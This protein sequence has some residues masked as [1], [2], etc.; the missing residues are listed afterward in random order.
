MIFSKEDKKRIGRNISA[1]REAYG[2]TS[3]IDFAIALNPKGEWPISDS[4][5]QK[6]EAG[7]YALREGNIRTIGALTGFSYSEIVFE[8]LTDLEKNSLQVNLET[9]LQELIEDEE[10]VEYSFSIFRSIYPFVT[11]D[12]A[13]QSEYFKRAYKICIEKIDKFDFEENDVVHV[14]NGFYRA[15]KDEGY[16][17]ILSALGRLYSAYVTNFLVNENSVDKVLNNQDVSLID[18][19]VNLQKCKGYDEDDFL[20]RKNYYLERY[21]QLLTSYMRKVMNSIEYKDFAYYFLALRYYYGIMDNSITKISDED[22]NI[23]GKS[24]MDS[25][26]AMQNKYALEFSEKLQKV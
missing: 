4:M 10:F 19:M 18:F 8:D 12:E 11:S 24:M 21:N 15:E 9:G 5:I 2:F 26:V 1:I 17:N 22:M 23:F 13:E 20:R 14:I 25:L 3:A 6:I 16:V 7:S